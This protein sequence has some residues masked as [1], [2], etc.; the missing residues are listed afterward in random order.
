MSS[1]LRGILFAILGL[2]LIAMGIAAVLMFY[3]GPSLRQQIQ[4]P[5]PD[6]GAQARVVIARRPIDLG[7][8]LSNDNV[9][10]FEM[11]AEIVPEGAGMDVAE[12]VGKYI[13]VDLAAGEIIFRH[14]LADPTNVTHD[15]G[16]VLGDDH[17]LM[18]FP[19]LDLMSRE[20][21][22]QRGDIVDILATL[23]EQVVRFD[24]DGEEEVITQLF[25]FDAHQSIEVTGMVLD[26]IYNEDTQKNEITVRAYLLALNPQ[27]ALVLKHLNDSNALFDIVLRAPTSEI[28]FDLTPVTE[29]YI[30][31]LYGLELLP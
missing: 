8:I 25:T 9:A 18:A 31:E 16:F 13:K 14:N 1:R 12:V 22:I 4:Q 2:V 3:W 24:I 20:S 5:T 29:E 17:V 27:D 19:A 30:K 28:L 11:P 7:E 26:I 10:Q 21:V 15:L 6:P 23:P